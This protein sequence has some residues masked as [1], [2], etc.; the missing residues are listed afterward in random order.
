MD[1]WVAVLRQWLERWYLETPS[2]E[3]A[4]PARGSPTLGLERYSFWEVSEFQQMAASSLRTRV[5]SFLSCLHA[6]KVR[7][8]LWIRSDGRRYQLLHGIDSS[9]PG[10]MVPG[11]QGLLHRALEGF[12]LGARLRPLSPQRQG[13]ELNFAQLLND[14][15]RFAFIT[16]IPGAIED[17]SI[18]TRIDE[19]LEGL[20]GVPF[21]LFVHSYPQQGGPI[22]EIENLLA[23]L[24]T[25]THQLSRQQVSRSDSSSFS[26]GVNRGLSLA[27][28]DSRSLNIGQALTHSESGPKEE[29]SSAAQ[30]L[31]LVLGCL[32]GGAAGLAL[33]P[34][35]AP[36]LAM[37]GGMIGKQIQQSISGAK[38]SNKALSQ[39]AS[40]NVTGGAQSSEQ[41]S[42]SVGDS[43]SKTEQHGT[44]H[45]FE[46]LNPQAQILEQLCLLYLNRLKAGRDYG[47]WKTTVLV[48]AADE[49]EL[50]LAGNVLFG[51][52]RG[53]DTHLEPLRLISIQPKR[54][55]MKAVW[56]A[57]TSGQEMP[58]SAALPPAN[59]L[60][61][62]TEGPNTILTSKELAAWV[63]PPGRDIAG[64]KVRT[65]SHFARNPPAHGP[66]TVRLGT[67]VYY[68]RE[69]IDQP[70][71]IDTKDI[72]RHI[73][74]AGTTGSGKTN[75]VQHF[76][77]ELQARHEPIPF[78]VIE[79]AKSEYHDLYKQL[80]R[81]YE[82]KQIPQRPRWLR[83]GAR[84]SAGTDPAPLC[85]NP[86]SAPA[87]LPL[88]RHIEAIKILLQSCFTM[89]ESLP[90]VWEGL[91]FDTYADFGWNDLVSPVE[92]RPDR[93][94]P[95]FG[96]FFAESGQ[97]TGKPHPH[98]ALARMD[99]YA[100]KH[101]PHL[102]E[103]RIERAV[104]SLGYEPAVAANFIA[105]M[106]V[107][108]GSFRRGMKAEIFLPTGDKPETAIGELLNA[109]C[110]IELSDLNEPDIRRFLMGALF[111]RIYAEREA[112]H[113]QR[114]EREQRRLRHLLVLEEAH[115][116]V[117]EAEGHGAS[118]E[119][120]RQSNTVIADAFA[121]LRAYG[122]AILVADQSPALL[123]RSVL[124][125]ANTKV[126][127]RLLD[128]PDVAAIGD[129]MG[130]DELQRKELRHLE[131]G[132]C[133]V[134]TPH[135]EPIHCR[136][137]LFKPN[138]D[139]AR[140]GRTQT[141]S[142][143]P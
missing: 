116:L 71:E 135:S 115:H 102:T 92:I 55:L 74:I 12:L 16:G 105:A 61:P 39:S 52:L 98:P 69:L 73:F 136:V 113:R 112:E 91:L 31:G 53:R 58:A 56:E 131:V 125:N 141:R 97:R 11:F 84:A 138:N 44:Q 107:R 101:T 42:V 7:H 10:T 109:P 77:W 59:P 25:L 62:G 126:A 108:L 103:T 75:T 38:G 47:V 48:A 82:D 6:A 26:Q 79:P 8:A 88:G 46:M 76:L 94:F 57:V 4:V 78:M 143:L 43:S 123:S 140:S 63:L 33:S 65:I 110:F 27:Q 29:L 89:Q 99:E 81:R 134:T 106:R 30:S 100:R 50:R 130:L 85:L 28:S 2:L 51:I 40:G 32:A 90:Q 129:A 127:H 70:V 119:L 96:D 22:D 72:C 122:Q 142:K 5:V 87:G 24:V 20:T 64:V 41:R 23:T 111:L 3:F 66:D 86:F 35:L 15:R 132:N 93:R 139:S 83:V 21:D 34:P 36:Q 37:A 118:A 13:D 1:D 121:E 120:M 45:S 17:E 95:N 114:N 54:G 60:L 128:G 104:R 18:A 117:R 9:Q 14:N 68:G 137:E 133:A 67:L 80:L 19:A 49:E 124:R